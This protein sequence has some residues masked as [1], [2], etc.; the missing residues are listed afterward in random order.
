MLPSAVQT[1]LKDQQEM[2]SMG[3]AATRED[4]DKRSERAAN[5]LQQITPGKSLIAF[6]PDR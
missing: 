4:I 5:Q 6:N 3:Q 2:A 1:L